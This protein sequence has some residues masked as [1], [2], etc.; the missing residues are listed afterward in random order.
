MKSD[1]SI[2]QVFFQQI[3]EKLPSHISFVHEISELLGISYDSAYRR[4]RGDKA[5]SME[6]LKVLGSYYKISIDTL[7]NIGSKNVVF[8][9]VAVD[10]TNFNIVEWLHQIL[11]EVKRFHAAK[12]KEVIYSAKDV[13]VFYY[14]EFPE[15][16][17]FKIYFWQKTLFHFQDYQ[18]KL[19]VLDDLSEDVY[20]TGKQIIATS[21]KVPTIELWNEETFNSMI[22][23]IEY[24]YESGF[25][26]H[27]QDIYRLCEVL[28]V[29]V[30]HIQRQAEYGFKFQYDTSPDGVENS[31]KFYYNE[32]L[33]S[34]NTIFVT[35]DDIRVTYLTYNVLNLLIT[36]NP[37]FCDQVEHS[38]RILMKKS[39]LISG[40]SDKERNRFFNKLVDKI[41]GLTD[42]IS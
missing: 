41:K 30:R 16:A 27:K 36:T 9:P 23:Q 35:M 33:L 18:N 21:I 25:F 28:E 32:V 3:K 40:T 15:I 19:F 13:P 11:A 20:K 8:L 29:W 34:D 38:L 7:F 42:R 2:Q 4:I 12:E 22:R 24:C 10:E 26:A 5:L 37:T 39:N 6:E 1:F 17:A 31:F 14:F